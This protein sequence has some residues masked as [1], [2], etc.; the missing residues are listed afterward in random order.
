MLAWIRS[1]FVARPPAPRAPALRAPA[2]QPAAPAAEPQAPLPAR[3]GLGLD[4]ESLQGSMQERE[5]RLLA[6]VGLRVER[7][8]IEL[9]QLPSTSIGAIDLCA[10]PHVE[11]SEIV[12]LIERDPVLSSELLRVA[13]SV[14]YAGNEPAQTLHDAVLRV[15][16]RTLRSMLYAVSVRG[17]I[18][19]DRSLSTYAEEVWRQSSSC[20]A[21]A[22]TL[23]KPLGLEAERAYL[24]G[25]LHDVGK[26]PLLA[27]LRKAANKE[28]EVTP[29]LVG[30]MF[31]QYH[32]EAGAA[33]ARAWRL[34]EELIE[35]AARHHD[36]AANTRHAGSAALASLVHKIDLFLSLGSEDEFRALVHAAEFEQLAVA[37]ERRHGLLLQAQAAFEA[38][39]AEPSAR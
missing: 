29:A 7:R 12:A 1:L 18:L 2:A 14:L 6:R 23:A 13:N 32:E 26:L 20:A 16:L 15:G 17:A 25:L 8:Q 3:S 19:G 39:L 36:F 38:Q 35:V 5:Q 28:S 30:R 37:V 10:R 33:L 24:I 21:I 31:R 34:P 22:R 9:P 11:I 4:H 27:M